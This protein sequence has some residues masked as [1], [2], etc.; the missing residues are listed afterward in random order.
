MKRFEF[1]NKMPAVLKNKYLLTVLIFAIWLLLLDSNNLVAR[2]KDLRELHN[3]RN[4]KEYYQMRIETDKKKLQEL[5]TDNQ[6][7]EKFAREQ[8]RMK[9]GDEDLYI[10]LTPQEDRKI[11]R[12]NN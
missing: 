11:T 4:D 2:Y 8:Y 9:R 12:R 5:K 6:N 1:V 10:I 3:L 7:L